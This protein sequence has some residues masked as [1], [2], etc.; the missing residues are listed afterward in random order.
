MFGSAG[1]ERL[2]LGPAAWATEDA[3]I[4]WSG[5]TVRFVGRASKRCACAFRSMSATWEGLGSPVA[6][7]FESEDTIGDR[8]CGAGAWWS[9]DIG[10]IRG[11]V[12]L[13]AEYPE[14]A[15][16]R[17]VTSHACSAQ[18]SVGSTLWTLEP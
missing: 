6:V 4:Q 14:G 17:I 16:V 18:R 15:P 3:R 12:Q 13:P 7:E 9:G 1:G 8:A 10:V 2:F 5:D 11:T